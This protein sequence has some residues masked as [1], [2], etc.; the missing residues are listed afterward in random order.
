MTRAY[1]KGIENARPQEPGVLG[2]TKVLAGRVQV[3]QPVSDL[4]SSMTD[5]PILFKSSSGTVRNG[6]FGDSSFCEMV[7][8]GRRA[9][10]SFR[11]T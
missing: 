3:E 1:R 5:L 6:L 9:G 2:K 4:A 8:N 7:R 10:Y 11:R